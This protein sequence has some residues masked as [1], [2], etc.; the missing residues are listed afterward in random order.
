[1][2]TATGTQ[3]GE[4]NLENNMTSQQCRAHMERSSANVH[5]AVN[6]SM[7][8]D[9]LPLAMAYVPMQQWNETYDVEKALMRGTIFPEL[10][11]PFC[12]KGA[13]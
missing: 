10:D 5:A 13:R 3:L 12:G 1:M 9:M 8:L 7:P 2:N 11:L 4:I 6:G